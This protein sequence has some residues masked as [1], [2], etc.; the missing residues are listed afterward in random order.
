MAVSSETRG[1][2]KHEKWTIEVKKIA[3]EV[4]YC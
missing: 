3:D 1:F 2:S 4:Y